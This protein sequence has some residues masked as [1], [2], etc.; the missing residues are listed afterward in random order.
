MPVDGVRSKNLLSLNYKENEPVKVSPI[1]EITGLDG[2]VFMIDADGLLKKIASNGLHIPLDENHSFGGALG[3]FDKDSFELRDDGIYAK[4]ELNKNGAALVN[5]KVYRYLSPVYDTD[6]RYVTGLDS[7]GLVNRPNLLNNT[8]N[9]KG[10]NMNELEELKAKF[11]ALQK[12]LETS[13]AANET[14]K[15][16]LAEAKKPAEQPKQEESKTGSEEANNVSKQI[17]ELGAKIAKMEE[18]FKGIFGKSELEK[19]AKANA[20][21]DEQ[22]KIARMLGLSDEEYKGGMN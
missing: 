10:E 5:D 15:A 11:E 21:T 2:R 9:S 3:W 18:N 14:L 1:G 12:E 8:I 16:E 19:N 13:K 6:G 17:A 22:S 7:V 20:L 4:L